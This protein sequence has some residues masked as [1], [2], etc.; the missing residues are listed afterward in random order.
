MP[1]AAQEGQT[2]WA[3]G[4]RSSSCPR[5]TP[6]G[7]GTGA[8]HP[9]AHLCR[10]WRRRRHLVTALR[11]A[12]RSGNRAGPG[13]I[14]QGGRLSTD[15]LCRAVNAPL[16]CPGFKR[17]R[18]QKNLP[19]TRERVA[20]LFAVPLARARR[21]HRAQPPAAGGGAGPRQM[22]S[23]LLFRFQGSHWNSG[24]QRR[25]P[26]TE[27]ESRPDGCRGGSRS[28]GLDLRGRRHGDR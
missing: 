24:R 14:A 22:R 16:T 25:H 19:Y 1:K 8:Q 26:Q 27:H 18:G 13:I 2:S 21:A 23:I 28:R 6:S 12:S 3:S 20:H 15:K 11:S 17:R 4:Q 7:C 9:A 5:W 10:A